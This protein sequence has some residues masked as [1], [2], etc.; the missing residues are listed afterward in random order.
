MDPATT[1]PVQPLGNS[2]GIIF[3]DFFGILS[4]FCGRK[5]RDFFFSCW[6]Q[7]ERRLNH[8]EILSGFAGSPVGQLVN[9]TFGNL[10]E[11]SLVPLPT[12]GRN[13]F[14]TRKRL[15]G[16]SKGSCWILR[17]SSRSCALTEFSPGDP[18][19]SRWMECQHGEANYICTWNPNESELSTLSGAET[20]SKLNHSSRNQIKS[21][22]SPFLSL[23]R[24]S[25]LLIQTDWMNQII[26]EWKLPRSTCRK[27]LLWAFPRRRSPAS[28]I[29]I[30][31]SFSVGAT[32]WLINNNNKTQTKLA[33][34]DS[35][36]HTV[37]KKTRRHKTKRKPKQAP[38]WRC[39]WGTV[40]AHWWSEAE[41]KRRSEWVSVCVCVCV[42][43]RVCLY[44]RARVCVCV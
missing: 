29:Q 8:L 40:C 1:T 6:N 37:Q 26:N 4:G 41:K 17:D 44:Q 12:V 11:G 32:H 35:R 16:D 42:C 43:A 30:S 34:T 28:W 22:C 24:H 31:G 21:R 20:R 2:S 23:F 25:Q 19:Q 7:Q 18:H 10:W 3:W 38:D 15:P 13:S 14:G 27:R 5:L 39:D 9:G 33:S 36:K